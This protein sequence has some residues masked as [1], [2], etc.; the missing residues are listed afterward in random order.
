MILKRS[1]ASVAM[2]VVKYSTRIDCG[3][4]GATSDWTFATLDYSSYTSGVSVYQVLSDLVANYLSTFGLSLD[5]AQVNPGPTL[6]PFAWK[7]KRVSDCLRE[8][9]DKTGWVCRFGPYKS[10]AIFA[11]GTTSA[12]YTI[13]DANPYCQ[14][15]TWS[16]TD[17]IPANNVILTCGPTTSPSSTPGLLE[18]FS[19]TAN[20]TATSWVFPGAG[21]GSYPYTPEGGGSSIKVGSAIV[22]VSV[23]IDQYHWEPSTATLSVGSWGGG[24]PPSAGT[25]IWFQRSFTYPLI[26]RAATGETPVITY[27]AAAPDV[28]TWAAG[29]QL[30]NGLLAQLDQQPRDISLI[31]NEPGWIYSVGLY[32]SITLTGRLVCSALI[33]DFSVGVVVTHGPD[34]LWHYQIRALEN[35]IFQGSVLDSWRALLG[36]SSSSSTQPVI[37]SGGGGGGGTGGISGTPGHLAKFTGPINVG[38]ATTYEDASNNL[39]TA[40]QVIRST[41][42]VLRMTETDAATDQKNWQW[43]TDGGM[44]YLEALNDAG[45]TLLSNPI[46]VS[47]SGLVTLYNDFSVFGS[48]QL[49]TTNIVGP[50]ST[51]A[52]TASG[53]LI[54]N[55]TSSLKGTNIDGGLSVSS[56]NTTLQSLSVG[57]TLGVTGA[58]T[59]QNSLTVNG[60]T[61]LQNATVSGTL[62]VTGA[63]TFQNNLTVN[64]STTLGSIAGH[65]LPSLTS[66]YD[67]GSPTKIWRQGYL[68]QLNAI[69][70]VKAT[71][72]IFGGYSTI[73]KDAGTFA[74]DV[75]STDT[76]IDFGHTMSAS[77][78]VVVRATDTSG[79]IREEYLQI[80]TGA[81]TGTR[82]PVTRDLSGVSSPDPVWTKGTPYLVLGTGTS[83]TGDGR[84]DLFAYDGRPR[85][86]FVEQGAS[87]NAQTLRAILGN[88]NT[89]YGYTSNIYGAAFGSESGSNLTIDPTNGLR[90]RYG[91]TVFAQM[92]SSLFTLGAPGGNRVTWNGTDLTVVSSIVTINNQGITLTPSP[93]QPISSTDYGYKFRNQGSDS[94]WFGLYGLEYPDASLKRIQI[95]CSGATQTYF[96]VFL[97]GPGWGTQVLQIGAPSN[98][99]ANDASLSF[100]G[101]ALFIG[102]ITE[103]NRSKPIGE[104]TAVPFNASDFIAE[105]GGTWTVQAADVITFAYSLVGK[106]IIVAFEIQTTDTSGTVSTLSIKIPGGFVPART[107]RNTITTNPAAGSN[108]GFVV[109]NATYNFLRCYANYAG[110]GWGASTGGTHVWGQISFEVS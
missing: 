27:L 50:L 84:I 61:G 40:G 56:G 95:Q 79:V 62:G 53:N 37:T 5:P 86:M 100:S 41:A 85:I 47:R 4:Y 14:D 28:M 49:N 54:V 108:V 74:A 55:G 32:V 59:L 110:G 60:S 7:D 82:Y 51:A 23:G 36:S 46:R 35:T 73:G 75:L 63:A 43:V 44:L 72:T 76:T 21:V 80:G 1:I 94:G 64:G 13:T 92:A 104:W 9:C 65:L 10:V 81:P 105:G 93:A 11:P 107:T 20:G 90:I 29:I 38:D 42:P 87:Y 106:I 57:G 70:F 68:S 31:S 101:N 33:T 83:T 69:L 58:A 78:F 25:V 77:D 2:G 97:G 12:P 16:D 89:F 24:A 48:T 30:A 99:L 109:A 22:N 71:Q 45:N 15:L 6:A 3:D 18:S 91:S 17:K 66:T 103:R 52:I 26:I 96:D 8:I 98:V 34:P 102:S 39:I 19:V 67:I 88:L